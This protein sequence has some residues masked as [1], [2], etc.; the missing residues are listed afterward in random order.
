MDVGYAQAAAMW[1]V[2]RLWCGIYEPECQR[3]W[4]LSHS[5]GDMVLDVCECVCS[6]ATDDDIH[7]VVLLYIP[8]DIFIIHILFIYM[9]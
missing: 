4:L 8:A 1:L 3:T 9:H 6:N 5:V 7:T 2:A